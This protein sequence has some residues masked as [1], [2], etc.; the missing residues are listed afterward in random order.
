MKRHILL[1]SLLGILII[2]N[3][4]TEK[5]YNPYRYEERKATTEQIRA[6][7]DQEF[8]AKKCDAM[9]LKI[10][11]ENYNTTKNTQNL[12][13]ISWDYNCPE[14]IDFA[15][16][17]INT[18]PDKEARKI[19]IEMLGIRKHYDAIPLLLNHVKKEIPS[20]EKIVAASVLATLGKKTEAL[21]ILDCNCYGM[22]E[23]DDNCIYTYFGLF[24]KETAIK[25]FEHYFNKPETQLEAAAWL[26]IFGVY[27]KTFP[28]FVEFLKNN[29]TYSKGI[30]YSLV[31]LAAIGTE[32]A[33]EIIKQQ[34]KNNTSLI[35]RSAVHTLD[36]I[37]GRWKK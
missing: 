19:A 12:Q 33:L 18:S 31:G 3:A 5:D 35:A 1:L 14:V 34:T 23:M 28:L 11:I 22:D 30:D 13:S 21:E 16:D 8:L 20:D 15:I 25:Y 37:E 17:L 6:K 9:Q 36:V 24:D 7:A 26:A 4:Q 2:A 32:E 29:T 27:D 10:L